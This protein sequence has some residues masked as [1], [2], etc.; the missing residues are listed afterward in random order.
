MVLLNKNPLEMNPKNLRE[1]QIEKILLEGKPYK[2]G[3]G[4]FGMLTGAI[5]GRNR[6]I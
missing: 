4:I 1:L 6:K 3:N 5:K 2:S